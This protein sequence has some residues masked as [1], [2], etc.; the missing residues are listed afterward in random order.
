MI[1]VVL[2]FFFNYHFYQRLDTIKAILSFVAVVKKS[3][4]VLQTITEGILVRGYDNLFMLISFSYIAQFSA[5]LYL[6]NFVL[7]KRFELSLILL[8]LYN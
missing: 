5:R 4:V 3:K 8:K 1:A 7:D 2:F 6:L